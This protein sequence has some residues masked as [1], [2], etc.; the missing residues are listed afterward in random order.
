MLYGT[1]LLPK[2]LNYA[3]L[4]FAQTSLDIKSKTPTCQLNPLHFLWEIKIP[5]TDTGII[6]LNKEWRCKSYQQVL[7]DRLPDFVDR[8]TST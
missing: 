2:G 3:H 5:N 8:L 6:E 4:K 1:I 7:L